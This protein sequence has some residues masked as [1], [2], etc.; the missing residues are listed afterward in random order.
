LVLYN[1]AKP[2]TRQSGFMA[3]KALAPLQPWQDWW[4]GRPPP[5]Q[6]PRVPEALRKATPSQL[7]AV[8]GIAQPQRF[9]KPLRHLG[10]E[11]TPCP[12]PD[13]ARLDQLP[14]PDTVA[15]VVMTEKDAVKLSPD[16]LKTQRP[17]TQVWVAALDFQP[18]K[19]FW[20]ALNQRLARLHADA[21]GASV[22]PDAAPA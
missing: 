9:F 5:S 6:G 3:L 8:A 4:D 15:H 21:G 22:A 20:Q 11:F 18:D 10:L 12:L 13:H 7:W 17:G 14:W 1:A 2:S 16:Q 19:G